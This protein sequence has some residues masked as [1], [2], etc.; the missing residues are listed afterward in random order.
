LYIILHLI[1]YANFADVKIGPKR[2]V[3]QGVGQEENLEDSILHPAR[4]LK[5]K[6]ND[7]VTRQLHIIYRRY[8]VRLSFLR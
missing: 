8:D 6:R 2:N 7:N 4:G 5:R 1:A 3:G